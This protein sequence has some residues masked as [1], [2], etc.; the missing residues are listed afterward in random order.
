MNKKLGK[1]LHEL[2][3]EKGL[4]Q[5]DVAAAIET[6]RQRYAR[7]EKGVNDITLETLTKVA[8][9]FEVSITSITSVL[10]EEPATAYRSGNGESIDTVREMLDLFYA[11]KRVHERKHYK[12]GE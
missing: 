8:N 7:M 3:V 6:T 9:L 5:D 1:R 12:D 2:R 4:T 11:N 10:E